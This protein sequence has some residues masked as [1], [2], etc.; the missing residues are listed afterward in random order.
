[1]LAAGTIL[2]AALALMSSQL[3]KTAPDD[4]AAVG[5]VEWVEQEIERA[6]RYEMPGDIHVAWR[7]ELFRIMTD[8]ELGAVED[9][10]RGH[11][12][13]PDRMQLMFERRRISDGPDVWAGELLFKDRDH[14]RVN[15]TTEH[16]DT[17][18]DMG[19]DGTQ[20]WQLSPKQVQ[21][22]TST[23][24]PQGYEPGTR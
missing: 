5:S 16:L 22:L 15:R 23:S 2:I 11:P 4:E 13:H 10:V 8:R 21:L 20:A 18:A 14:W 9:R 1:M 12:D 17:F 7:D 6:R 3:A 24:P 19:L